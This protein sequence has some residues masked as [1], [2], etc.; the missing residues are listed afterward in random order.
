MPP[1]RRLSQLS[2]DGACIFESCLV[3]RAILVQRLSDQ[4]PRAR[5]ILRGILLSQHLP[6]KG[7]AGPP[8]CQHMPCKHSVFKRALRRP[9]SPYTAR[10]LT[11]L[12]PFLVSQTLHS[13]GK[14]VQEDAVLC[15]A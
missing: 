1:L 8:K 12:R 14:A 11:Q 5:L 10:D 2:E 13:Q 6:L 3:S 9:A 7:Q 15:S 4:L